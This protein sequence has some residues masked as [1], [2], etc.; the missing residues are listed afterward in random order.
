MVVVTVFV[1]TM[2]VVL[3]IN[4]FAHFKAIIFSTCYT[5]FPT[6]LDIKCPTS[7]IK[8]RKAALS[9]KISKVRQKKVSRGIFT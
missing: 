8:L 2:Y 4:I 1:I 7:E 5:I 6:F 9:G 3:R